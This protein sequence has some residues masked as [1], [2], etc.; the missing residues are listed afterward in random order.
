MTLQLLK[1]A[2]KETQAIIENTLSSLNKIATKLNIQ[3][4]EKE[5]S[6]K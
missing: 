5:I 1:E 6:E 4:P 3:I 2:P